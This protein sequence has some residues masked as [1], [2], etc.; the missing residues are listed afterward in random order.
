MCAGRTTVHLNGVAE[1]LGSSTLRYIDVH[2]ESLVAR[3]E[4]VNEMNHCPQEIGCIT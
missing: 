3:G 2:T 1:S 4:I